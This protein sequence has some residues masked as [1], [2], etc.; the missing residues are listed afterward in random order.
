MKKHLLFLLLA[1]SMPLFAQ[2]TL[3]TNQN[4]CG[5][6]NIGYCRVSVDSSPASN[7][8]AVTFDNRSSGG[9]LQLNRA[10]SYILFHGAY[11]GFDGNPDGSHNAY[12]GEGTYDG[13]ATLDS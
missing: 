12:D 7:F 4:G 2:T 11:S 13:T 6:K 3:T 8:V 1:M 5:A 10:D 9:G